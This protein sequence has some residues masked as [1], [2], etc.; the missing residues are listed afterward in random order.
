MYRSPWNFDG[1][2][3]C[4]ESVRSPV[5]AA[6]TWPSSTTERRPA[7]Q[8]LFRFD[9]DKPGGF[10]PDAPAFARFLGV[11]GIG[12]LSRVE[13]ARCRFG[14]PGLLREANFVVTDGCAAFH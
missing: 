12:V 1:V 7:G 11:R 3:S 4:Q 2:P 5:T 14:I 9:L 8:T 6:V 10:S 13:S